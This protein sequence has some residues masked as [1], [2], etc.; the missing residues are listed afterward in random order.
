MPYEIRVYEK[1]NTKV[2]NRASHI[3]AVNLAARLSRKQGC[4]TQVFYAVP[5]LHHNG[6]EFVYY[7]AFNCGVR[8]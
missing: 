1:S 5:S 4:T 8:Q 6:K 2:H 7:M 3:H